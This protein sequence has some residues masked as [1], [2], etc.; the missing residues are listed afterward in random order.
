MPLRFA[1][2]FRPGRWRGFAAL[3]LLALAPKCL[4]CLAAWLGLGTLLGIGG[5]ELC[6][7]SPASVDVE[8]VAVCVGIGL[9]LLGF[10]FAA[11]RARR[12][13]QDVSQPRPP[14]SG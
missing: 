6:G 13:T 9:V 7:A 2:F 12:R 4:L 14:V 5:P 11:S 8:A 10:G 1:E 3:G